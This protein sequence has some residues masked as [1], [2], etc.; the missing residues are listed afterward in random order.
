MTNDTYSLP[1]QV[2]GN[3]RGV[4]IFK[5]SEIVLFRAP[6]AVLVQLQ[7]W[8]ESNKNIQNLGY[9]SF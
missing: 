3:V 4:L 1:P 2:I 6:T 5:I 8:G 7:W 9:K